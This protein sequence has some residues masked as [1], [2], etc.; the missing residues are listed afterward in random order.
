MKFVGYIFFY[1]I[2][3]S[4]SEEKIIVAPIEDMIVGEWD[5]K[6]GESIFHFFDEN[7]TGVF[8][9]EESGYSSIFRWTFQSNPP[10][11][12][13][14]SGDRDGVEEWNE[15]D[16]FS[17][18]V[19]YEILDISKD[20]MEWEVKIMAKDENGEVYEKVSIYEL[21]RVL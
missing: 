6:P 15:E 2:L 4:C 14:L 16:W 20:K 19:V 9:A 11:I 12:L 13:R 1:L 5:Q 18:V 21:R 10:R 7:G 8:R 17:S 3:L